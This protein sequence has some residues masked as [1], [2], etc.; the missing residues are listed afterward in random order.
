MPAIV[1]KEMFERVQTKI[2]HNKKIAG[3]FKQESASVTV[4]ILSHHVGQG[5]MY[6]FSAYLRFKFR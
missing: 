2:A 6:T 1:D 4:Q 3:Y 5:D